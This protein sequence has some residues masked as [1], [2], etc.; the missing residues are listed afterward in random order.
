MAM[1]RFV[2]ALLAAGRF[3]EFFMRS[4]SAEV[5]LGLE[6]ASGRAWPARRCLLGRLADVRPTDRGPAAVDARPCGHAPVAGIGLPTHEGVPEHVPQLVV[7]N[8]RRPMETAACQRPVFR[9]PAGH[10]ATQAI[11]SHGA[12][13]VVDAAS[14]RG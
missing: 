2:I 8:S 13:V 11:G 4:D 3:L 12:S 1:T 10:A 7:S 14:Q 5:A 6:V 9:A